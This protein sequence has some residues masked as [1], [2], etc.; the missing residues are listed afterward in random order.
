MT[1]KK[2]LAILLA[3]EDGPAAL[4]ELGYVQAK[5]AGK[6]AY[7]K[8]YAQGVAQGMSENRQKVAEVV[9][10]AE[11]TQLEAV[12][13]RTLI[14]RGCDVAEALTFIQT[15]RA[16]KSKK[17]VVL[18]AGTNGD[19][20]KNNLVDRLAKAINEADFTADQQ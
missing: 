14:R 16:K 13:L 10:L 5:V 12:D 3:H 18:S 20:G 8:G 6:E 4:A 2:R 17:Q 11:Q 15:M 19:G 7:D 1:T 9:A